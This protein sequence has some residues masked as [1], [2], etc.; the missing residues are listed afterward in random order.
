MVRHQRKSPRLQGYDYSQAGA[1]FVTICTHGR[2]CIFG[3]VVG[4]AMMLSRA[5]EIAH[6][7]WL[8]L[9]DHHPQVELDLFV[10]M[11]N[12]VHGI[13]ILVVDRS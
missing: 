11:P 7:R 1:Y 8:T 13:V 12:Q 10:V 6:E 5:G 3:G 4:N 2:A 9:P